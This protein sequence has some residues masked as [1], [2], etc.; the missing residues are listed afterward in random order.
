MNVAAHLLLVFFFLG[1]TQLNAQ[2]CQVLRDEHFSVDWGPG[3]QF[4]E[5]YSVILPK[6]YTPDQRYGAVYFLHGRGGDRHLIE[7]LGICAQLDRLVDEGK[8]PFVVIAPDGRAPNNPTDGYWMNGA[9]TPERWGDLVTHDLVAE[10]ERKFSLISSPKGRVIAGIS[11]GGHGALQLSL[12]YPGIFGAIGMHSPVFR[13]QEE[14]AADFYYQ[15][16]TGTDYQH[17]DPFSLIKIFQKKL[18]VPI[19]MD[20]GAHDQFLRNTVNCENMLKGM[21]YKK[22][23]HVG[24]DAEGAHEMGYWEYHL[25][26]YVDWYSAR[27]SQKSK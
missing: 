25:S 1:A 18:N 7:G 5:Y 9:K 14:A 2:A 15:F 27:L 10:A 6:G 12:N 26:S 17:R 3:H 8:T 11:M 13:T 4:E 23:F 21:G 16:G 20:M 19:Y 22:E 24:E